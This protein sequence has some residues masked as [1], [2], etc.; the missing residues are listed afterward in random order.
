MKVIQSF[1]T[2]RGFTWYNYY[3]DPFS[4]HWVHTEGEASD[5]GLVSMQNG[6]LAG[7]RRIIY[8]AGYPR[9]ELTYR[10]VYVARRNGKNAPRIA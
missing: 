1:A 2:K 7:V 9:V 3:L 6:E 10:D 5:T 4:I 8:G